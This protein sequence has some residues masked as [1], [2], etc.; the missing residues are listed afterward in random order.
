MEI[1]IRLTVV[2]D[3]EKAIYLGHNAT[4]NDKNSKGSPKESEILHENVCF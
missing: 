3:R 1:K 2:F 4:Y